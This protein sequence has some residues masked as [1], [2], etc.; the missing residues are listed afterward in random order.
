MNIDRPK[1]KLN[2]PTSVHPAYRTKLNANLLKF[3]P[4]DETECTFANL[5]FAIINVGAY[6]RI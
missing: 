5:K 1:T 4:I 3:M 6:K 2:D